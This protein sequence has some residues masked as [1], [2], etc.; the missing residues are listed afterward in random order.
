MRHIAAKTLA[1]ALALFF[2]ATAAG[3]VELRL[4]AVGGAKVALDAIIATTPRRP[5]TR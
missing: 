3:A 4:L 5:A 2:S 1:C